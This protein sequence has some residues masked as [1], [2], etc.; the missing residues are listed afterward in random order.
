MQYWYFCP[1]IGDGKSLANAF[2]PAVADYADVYSMQPVKGTN[3]CIAS[4]NTPSAIS[5]TGIKL[6]SN[7][8]ASNISTSNKNYVQS[9]LG[10]TL[11]T[12]T[13]K[14]LMLALIDKGLIPPLVK[15]WDGKERLYLG[16]LL[17]GDPEPPPTR[18]TIPDTFDRADAST[19]GTASGGFSWTNVVA[20]WGITS[21]RAQQKL[22]YGDSVLAYANSS[23][24]SSDMYAQAVNY[25]TD[26]GVVIC[27]NNDSNPIYYMGHIADSTHA[28]IYRVYAGPSYESLASYTITWGNTKVVKITNSGSTLTL[29][30]NG[31]ELG[32][33]TNSSNTKYNYAGMFAYSDAASND[34]FEAGSLAST[35]YKD[36]GTRYKVTVQGFKDAAARFK[37]TVR[38]YKDTAARYVSTARNYVNANSRYR[39]AATA[40]KNI[41]LRFSTTVQ[42]YVNAATRYVAQGQSYKN[43]SGRYKVAVQ[44]FKDASTRYFTVGRAYVNIAARYLVQVSGYKHAGTRYQVSVRAYINA[45]ARFL[46]T[47]TNYVDASGR[48]QT[49]ARGFADAAARYIVQVAGGNFQNAAAR[50]KTIAQSLKDIND[51][52]KITVRNYKD[53]GSLYLTSAGNLKDVNLLYRVWAQ[54]FAHADTRYRAV[55]QS[56]KDASGRGV[57]VARAYKDMG[58]RYILSAAG[59]FFKDI[60]TRYLTTG[61]SVR[62]A[63]GRYVVIA[64]ATSIVFPD[65]N[66][67]LN[68][69]N[70]DLIMGVPDRNLSLEAYNHDLT[71]AMPERNLSVV[72]K[73]R[74]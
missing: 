60:N 28:I 25:V 9:A 4:A 71:A 59:Y 8:K 26:A 32:H 69:Y 61:S 18:G 22:G 33:V 66:L 52:Y 41:S 68:V 74:D 45:G 35:A 1:V 31:T 39:V 47:V 21:N 20:G 12:G 30:Y 46:A 72:I 15:G 2:R 64:D 57:F 62:P 13:V 51:R 19:L 5:G 58:T 63:T 42:S 17:D 16:D 36:T 37:T 54:A 29:F 23:L 10:I 7:N 43:I 73:E 48:Y 24:G 65:R 14:D 70:R 55:I 3:Y 56:F 67:T 34:S 49:I 27:K 53:A 38:N 40:Y 11:N 50:Y 44:N 6:L